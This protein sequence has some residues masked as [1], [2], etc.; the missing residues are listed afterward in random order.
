M[1][2]TAMNSKFLNRSVSSA[3][4]KQRYQYQLYD[5][6]KALKNKPQFINQELL[7]NADEKLDAVLI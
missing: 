4:T 7:E 3:K 6:L 1:I 5:Y 2:M